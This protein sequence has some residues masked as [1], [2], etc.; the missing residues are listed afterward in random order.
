MALSSEL[1]YLELLARLGASSDHFWKNTFDT[2]LKA[3]HEL[4]TEDGTTHSFCKEFLPGMRKIRYAADCT[5]KNA[6]ICK[7]RAPTYLLPVIKAEIPDQV[8]V[9]TTEKEVGTD[10][11][12]KWAPLILMAITLVVLGIILL[13]ICLHHYCS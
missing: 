8:I 9:L 13:A 1:E 11:K 3:D 12:Q 5:K 10:K 4:P 6:F 2:Y 7:R